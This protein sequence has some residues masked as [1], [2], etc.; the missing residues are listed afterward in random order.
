MKISKLALNKNCI[1]FIYLIYLATPN[2]HKMLST[3]L[4]EDRRPI[5]SNARSDDNNRKFNHNIRV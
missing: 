2:M 1:F 3:L 4:N 5:S